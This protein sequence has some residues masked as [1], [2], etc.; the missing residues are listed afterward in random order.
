MLAVDGITAAMGAMSVCRAICGSGM[1]G[2]RGHC[3]EVVG[4]EKEWKDS[5]SGLACGM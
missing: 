4:N 3:V 1:M 2:E 5:T